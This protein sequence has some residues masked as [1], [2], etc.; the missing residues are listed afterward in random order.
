MR[1]RY[2]LDG[3]KMNSLKNV[4]TVLKESLE[5]PH[6]YG[7]NLDA[8]YDCLTDMDAEIIMIHSSMMEAF[9]GAYYNKLLGVFEK[10]Q[11]ENPLLDFKI[12]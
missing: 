3:S 5:L 1:K 6:Y 4:H 12:M 7:C 2:V 9:F 11:K 8:L 10:A